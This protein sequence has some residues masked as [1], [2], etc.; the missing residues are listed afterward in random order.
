MVKKEEF[1]VDTTR[2]S[3]GFAVPVL[4]LTFSLSFGQAHRYQNE[5]FQQ[6]WSEAQHLC[7]YFS[8]GFTQ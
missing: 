7:I 5:T 6:Q 3:P 8:V 1:T 2:V 4:I